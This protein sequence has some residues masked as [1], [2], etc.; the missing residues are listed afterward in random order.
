M[1]KMVLPLV[2]E[3]LVDRNDP[4]SPQPLHDPALAPGHD[5]EVE[6]VR[7]MNDSAPLHIVVMGVS[8]SGKSTVAELLGARLDWPVAEADQFHPQAN[9][10]KMA[11]GHPLNDEDRWPWL[12][13]IRDWISLENAIG[14]NTIVTCSAL[15][16]SYRDALR[17][18]K[19]HVVFVHLD[20]PEELL[21][22][23]MQGR[24]GHFMPPALLPSQLNTLE[25]LSP[26]EEAITLNIADTPEQI[27]NQILNRFS[28]T[29]IR[30]EDAAERELKDLAE[31]PRHAS[32][33]E[34]H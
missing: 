6:G 29:A 27:V 13:A 24:S 14:S 33:T 32:T 21:A 11:S 4:Q 3:A 8:G 34:V 5:E 30:G 23:R 28:L 17:E 31:I 9:I 12:H 10:D 1:S 7:T 16:R 26:D 18:A 20:G 15:K 25:P 2:R 22:T 19:G